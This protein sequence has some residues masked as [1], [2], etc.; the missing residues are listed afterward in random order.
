MVCH[1]TYKDT[2]GKWLSPLEIEK[3]DKNNYVKL[4]DKTKVIVGPS[5]SMSKSKKN[6]V[7]PESMIKSFGADAVRWFIL[8][9]SPPEKDVQ[10]SNQGVNASHKFLQKL[11]NLMIT[12]KNRPDSKGTL[13]KEFEGSINNYIVKITNL[14]N[15][16][17]LNVA[18][19]NIYE[20]F[21]L[22]SSHLNR[23]T[24]NTCLKSSFINLMKILI[25]F[26]P[27]LANECLEQLNEKNMDNWPEIDKTSISS[28]KIK[29]AVQIDGKTREVVQ[30]TKDLSE[31]QFLEEIKKFDKVSKYLKDNKIK[32]IIYVKNKIIN[33]LTK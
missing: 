27:H 28:Q 33:I 1:E 31:N 25:P 12:I 4:S 29:V 6:V 30:V 3:K 22:F 7:D 8:S 16:F 10:W 14:I 26:T 19:A 2:S 18:V 24:S 5:E 9:D 32:K 23:D 13:N 21:N 11:Y 17:Q 15:N 20:I